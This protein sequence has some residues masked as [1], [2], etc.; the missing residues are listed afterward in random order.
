MR[1]IVR[2]V[3]VMCDFSFFFFSAVWF[4]VRAFFGSCVLATVMCIQSSNFIEK[5]TQG[6]HYG[7]TFMA[8]TSIDYR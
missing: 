6:V 3:I 8:G 2:R 1:A 7:S 5:L 4:L